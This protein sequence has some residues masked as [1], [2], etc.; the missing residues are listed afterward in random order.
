M[1]VPKPLMSADKF[2]VFNIA[3][4]DLEKLEATKNFPGNDLSHP[5]WEPDEPLGDGKQWDAVH[6]TWKNPALGT[7]SNGQAG[8]VSRWAEAFNWD[9]SMSGLAALPKRMDKRFNSLFAAAPMITKG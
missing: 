2:P 7:G 1:T 3:S 4:N 9:K 8:F 5:E 6:E